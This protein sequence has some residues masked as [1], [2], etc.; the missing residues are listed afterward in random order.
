MNRL[1]DKIGKTKANDYRRHM[2]EFHDFVCAGGFVP[3]G[4]W[5]RAHEKYDCGCPHSIQV[6]KERDS[7]RRP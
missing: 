2:K 1:E 3:S 7:E 5:C 6:D 4:G